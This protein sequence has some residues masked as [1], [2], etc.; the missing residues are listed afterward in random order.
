MASEPQGFSSL[1]FQNQVRH[2][3]LWHLFAL[4]T[5]ITFLPPI[6]VRSRPMRREGKMEKDK[7]RIENASREHVSTYF[8]KPTSQM[9]GWPSTL[10]R[11]QRSVRVGRP[12][13]PNGCAHP[14]SPVP[15]LSPSHQRP[16]AHWPAKEKAQGGAGTTEAGT[17]LQGCVISW[18]QAQPICIQC[19]TNTRRKG[20]TSTPNTKA[21]GRGGAPRLE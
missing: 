6:F 15:C 3:R 17:E 10:L 5:Q 12:S 20:G 18:L 21:T 14:Q 13:P 19:S 2:N 11:H 7:R 4:S 1:S 16:P 8:W 9:R